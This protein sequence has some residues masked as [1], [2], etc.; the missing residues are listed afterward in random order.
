MRFNRPRYRLAWQYSS[1]DGSIASSIPAHQRLY[2]FPGY[3]CDLH[4]PR[5]LVGLESNSRADYYG[6]A[7][8]RLARAQ[9]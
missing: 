5:F 7:V 4:S 2:H 8:R 9:V 6:W 3:C 1:A